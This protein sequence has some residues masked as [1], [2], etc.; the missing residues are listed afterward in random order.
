MKQLCNVFYLMKLD[1]NVIPV[2]LFLF[3]FSCFSFLLFYLFFFIASAHLGIDFKQTENET[4][5]VAYVSPG[6]PRFF[7]IPA[8]FYYHYY[9]YYHYYYHY[10]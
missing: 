7:P 5:I 3:S 2:I 1:K 10:H 6:K 4:E 9:H 8:Y